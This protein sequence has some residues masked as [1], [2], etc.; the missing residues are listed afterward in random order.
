[1][2]GELLGA[3][4]ES[5]G[6]HGGHGDG[7]T[8]NQ[9]DEDVVKTATLGVVERRVEDDDFEDDEDSDGDQTEGPDLSENLLQVTGAVVVLSDEGGSATEERVSASGDDHTLSFTS[10]ASRATEQNS[11][12]III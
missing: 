5:D 3:D 2:L 1:M 7:N 12:V 10:L 6:E 9:K 11:S 8:I 4:C